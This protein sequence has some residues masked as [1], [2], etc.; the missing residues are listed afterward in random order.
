MLGIKNLKVEIEGKTLLKNFNLKI[1]KGEVHAL[2][3]P[4]G[5]GKSSLS[6]VLAGHPKY[7]IVEGEISYNGIIISDMPPEQRSL[8][9]LFVSFQYP[10]EISGISNFDFLFTSFNIRK[11]AKEEEPI[12][13]EAFEKLLEE[14]LQLLQMKREFITRGIN[15]GFSGGEKK[16]N[17]ILQ[18]ALFSPELAVLDEI[19][20][21]VDI[22]SLKVISENLNNLKT[23]KNSFLIITHYERL[24]SYVPVDYVHILKEGQLV[25]T[26]GAEL[27]KEIEKKGYESFVKK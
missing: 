14:K 19:D 10:V 26:G 6:K 24:L 5:A 15:E 12:D 8:M 13:K 25:R 27:A 20:S 11:K 2:M 23:K 17:E 9:G 22:D 3:G 4:N 7:Q 16:K 21:G 1:K 18:M